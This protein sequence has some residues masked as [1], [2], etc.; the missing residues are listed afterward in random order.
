MQVLCV[1]YWGSTH[2]RLL[3]VQMLYIRGG[4]LPFVSMLRVY[5]YHKLYSVHVQV[6]VQVQVPVQVQVQ[7]HVP[8]LCKSFTGVEHVHVQVHVLCGCSC[9]IF[10][11]H[12]FLLTLCLLHL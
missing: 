3:V 11:L 2:L 8:Y 5:R 4:L 7:V 1:L 9:Y 6:Q 10:F 12:F